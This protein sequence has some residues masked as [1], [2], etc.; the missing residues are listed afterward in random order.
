MLHGIDI[1]ALIKRT[2][3]IRYF[4]RIAI[5]AASAFEHDTHNSGTT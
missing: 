3:L 4:Y 1:A 2:H 5:K